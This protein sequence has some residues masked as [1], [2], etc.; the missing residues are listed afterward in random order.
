MPTDEILKTKGSA[1]E[2]ALASIG[3]GIGAQNLPPPTLWRDLV[4]RSRG[5]P[6]ACAARGNSVA[7]QHQRWSLTCASAANAG[8]GTSREG[9]HSGWGWDSHGS[10]TCHSYGCGVNYATSP[11]VAE[12][13]NA[14]A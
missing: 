14:K 12:M 11:S 13:A 1:R 7:V 2:D 6:P 9:F 10:V 8:L 3:S 5:P 4:A